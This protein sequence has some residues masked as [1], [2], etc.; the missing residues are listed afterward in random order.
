[1]NLLGPVVG[2][3]WGPTRGGWGIIA[4]WSLPCPGRRI[5]DLMSMQPEPWQHRRNVNI[6]GEKVDQNRVVLTLV[7]VDGE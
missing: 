5:G 3:A 6:T 7:P 4:A 1:M 2:V